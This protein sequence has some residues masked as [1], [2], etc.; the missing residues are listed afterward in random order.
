[1]ARKRSPW[2]ITATD[3][4]DAIVR[5]TPP[6]SMEELP[7]RFVVHGSINQRQFWRSVAAGLTITR[8]QAKPFSLEAYALDIVPLLD[9]LTS[10]EHDYPQH[11]W[12]VA[13]ALWAGN[14]M[15]DAHWRLNRGAGTRTGL[16]RRAQ[17]RKAGR[18]SAETRGGARSS[19]QA[20]AAAIRR[21]HPYS[22][23]YSTRWLANEICRTLQAKPEAVR[24]ALRAL[25]L[26]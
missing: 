16:R 17:S 7:K 8:D 3:G 23:T 10:F 20:K 1:M 25:G 6:F 19:I 11:A 2:R 21:A 18:K 22:R 15:A 13:F 5:L 9:T 24:K 4:L 12:V 26:K 14:K